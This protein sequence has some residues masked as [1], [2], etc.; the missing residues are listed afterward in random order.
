[1]VGDVFHVGEEAEEGAAFE[2]DVV[3]D[4]AAEMRIAGFEGVEGLGEG[5]GGGTSRVI[6][7]LLMLARRRRWRGSSM[8]MRGI[9][10]VLPTLRK[11]YL[12]AKALPLPA[13]YETRG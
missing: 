1:M 3:A 8:R 4:G 2:G 7:W 6:S 12:R 10:T 11:A 5:C 9:R 13:G